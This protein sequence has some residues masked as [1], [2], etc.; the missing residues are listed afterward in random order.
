MMHERVRVETNMVG[1]HVYRW[2]LEGGPLP[3]PLPAN[4]FPAGTWLRMV[5]GD[6][7]AGMLYPGLGQMDMESLHRDRYAVGLVS[8]LEHPAYP[9]RLLGHIAQDWTPVNLWNYDGM[10]L[11]PLMHRLRP[12]LLANGNPAHFAAKSPRLPP[13]LA[14]G[15]GNWACTNNLVQIN[16]RWAALQAVWAVG[17]ELEAPDSVFFRAQLLQPTSAA[18]PT[19]RVRIHV[20]FRAGVS[21][22]ARDVVANWL[23]LSP[24]LASHMATF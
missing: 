1:Y 22:Y 14:Y 11:S 2:R 18:I 3:V 19:A 13:G 17:G 7:V 15:V 10:F 8:E 5:C 12:A 20:F 24:S 23:R 9:N 4:Y 6:N 16:Q 21:T